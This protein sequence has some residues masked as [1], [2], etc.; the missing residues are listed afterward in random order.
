MQ[1][2]QI[3]TDRLYLQRVGRCQAMYCIV[4]SIEQEQATR[5]GQLPKY[6]ML[7]AGTAYHVLRGYQGTDGLYAINRVTGRRNDGPG[8]HK[9]GE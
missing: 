8:Q 9:H 6:Q 3:D 5:C 2:W 1:G 4:M 7:R